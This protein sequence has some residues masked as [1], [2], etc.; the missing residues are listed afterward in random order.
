MF[1]LSGVPTCICALTYVTTSS[2]LDGRVRAGMLT[3]AMDLA[4]S[5]SKICCLASLVLGVFVCGTFVV[6]AFL[7]GTRLSLAVVIADIQ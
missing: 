5:G 6:F 4:F 7:M 2:W 3:A 1:L